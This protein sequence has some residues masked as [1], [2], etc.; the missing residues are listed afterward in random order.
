MDVGELREKVDRAREILSYM[1]EVGS[2]A[3]YEAEDVESTAEEILDTLDEI[4]NG[5]K[6]N[7]DIEFDPDINYLDPYNTVVYVSLDTNK[8][9]ELECLIKDIK[10]ALDNLADE[11]DEDDE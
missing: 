10:D 7:T 5:D 6:I 9:D 11:D 3:A 4:F 1:K 2:E 8:Y